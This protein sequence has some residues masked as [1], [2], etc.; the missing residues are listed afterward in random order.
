MDVHTF[1]EHLAPVGRA[2]F[3]MLVQSLAEQLALL[4]RE[5]VV[6]SPSDIKV[7]VTVNSVIRTQMS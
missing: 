2:S 6:D 4:G 3:L 5:L 1:T 7:L